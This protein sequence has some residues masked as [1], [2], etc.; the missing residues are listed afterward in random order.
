M[1]TG[2]TVKIVAKKILNRIKHLFYSRVYRNPANFIRT[3]KDLIETGDWNLDNFSIQDGNIQIEGWA[4]VPDR[5][6]QQFSFTL[7]DLE[8]AKVEYPLPGARPDLKKHFWYMPN[9]KDCGF[10]CRISTGEK[11]NLSGN[12]LTI[13]FV[14]KNSGEPL[15]PR[16]NYYY[17]KG[18]AQLPLPE[19]H[20][21]MRVHGSD[22]LDSFLIEGYSTFKKVEL[23]L[24]ELSGKTYADFSNILDWGCGCGRI[25]RHFNDLK[26]SRITGID[27]DE[28]NARWCQEN[29]PFGSFHVV[30]LTP[31]TSLEEAS[32]DLI[33]G[34]SIFT[35]L[36]EEAQYDWLQELN[37]LAKR[38][39]YLLVTV[40]GMNT[41]ARMG[42]YYPIYRAL[43]DKGFLDLGHNPGLDS[44]LADI[45]YYRNTLHT[46][47]YIY[48]NWS[49]HFR[50][51]AIIPG[52][53]GNHQDLVIMQKE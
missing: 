24:E 5:K 1:Q 30:P 37:R 34:I 35:H 52:T 17:R 45:Q 44:V 27:V 43:I 19:P 47:E 36:N 7:N 38:D 51:L 4:V 48:Q 41:V 3:L 46:S 20:R 13:K 29:L 50:I 28:D 26:N 32:F 8:F 2:H 18:F 9:A 22:H 10:N 11:I 25:T 21:R 39:A 16:Q 42:T 15:N 53:I 31:P 40:S 33:V 49:R 14:H 6:P 12:D 23:A